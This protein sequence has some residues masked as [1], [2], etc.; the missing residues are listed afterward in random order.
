MDFVMKMLNLIKKALI[1]TIIICNVTQ[2]PFNN[3]ILKTNIDNTLNPIDGWAFAS[4]VA[5]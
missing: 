3:E 5:V 2:R 1:Y 4:W